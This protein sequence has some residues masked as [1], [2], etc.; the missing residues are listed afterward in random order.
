M[1]GHNNSG[2]TESVVTSTDC[3]PV[4]LDTSSIQHVFCFQTDINSALVMSGLS[5]VSE[6]DPTSVA[7]TN[8]LRQ[9][10][11]VAYRLIQ[12]KS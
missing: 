5:H 9:P 6:I 1:E 8:P 12:A 3:R 7:L 11:I 10:M 4:K 2:P